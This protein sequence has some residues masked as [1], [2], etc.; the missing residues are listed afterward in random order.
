MNSGLQ[1]WVNKAYKKVY[2]W[3]TN[4]GG[5]CSIIVDK[6]R[7]SP[8][9]LENKR[10]YM[11]CKK[12]PFHPLYNIN[13]CFFK[14]KD[15]ILCTRMC[16]ISH[17]I[18]AKRVFSNYSMEHMVLRWRSS[19]KRRGDAENMTRAQLCSHGILD[20]EILEDR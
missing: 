1:P 17:V 3:R 20:N 12:P 18:L 6:K 15:T 13:Q 9:I 19:V 14:R 11:S 8:C 4:F 5:L 2:C 10:T 16:P 7:S